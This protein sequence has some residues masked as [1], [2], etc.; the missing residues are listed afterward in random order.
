MLVSLA[1][2]DRHGDDAV[3]MD[4]VVLRAADSAG[5]PAALP[6]PL[7]HGVE[8]TILEQRDGWTKVALA[9]GTSGWLPQGAVE[10]VVEHAD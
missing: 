9:N 4:G 6:D 8:V 1:V 3:V 10:R 2:E 5:A 7:P